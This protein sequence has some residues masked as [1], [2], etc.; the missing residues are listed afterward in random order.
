VAAEMA[1]NAVLNYLRE[2]GI[3][4]HDERRAW[5]AKVFE[6]VNQRANKTN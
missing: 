4:E 5:I 3:Q 2:C 6:K 1:V